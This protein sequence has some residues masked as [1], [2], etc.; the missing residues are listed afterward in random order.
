M[1]RAA[2]HRSSGRKALW[3][4]VVAA[5]IA[6]AFVVIPFAS[7]AN[8]D[9][10][11]FELDG[12][13][14][15]DGAAPSQDWNTLFGATG[16]D[17]GGTALSKV[18]INDGTSSSDTG[19]GSGQTKDTADVSQWT[20]VT[21]T[22]T[23][24]KDNIGYAY[25]ANYV[26]QG[27][28]VLYFGQERAF[29]TKG[30]DANVGFWF[31]QDPQVGLNANGTFNGHHVDG[32]LLV[33]SEFT[34]G[35]SIAG[36]RVY[37]W[38][39]G[40]AV[41]VGSLN[42]SVCAAGVLGTKDACAITNSTTITTPWSN[43]ASPYF[44]EGG[45]NLSSLYKGGSLPCF[46]QFLT[47][48]RTSQAPNADL[49][50]FAFGGLNT[51]GRITIVKDAQPNDAQSF[52]FTAGNGLSPASFS[53]TDNGDAAAATQTFDKLQPGTYTITETNIP[54]AW[55]L[56]GVNCTTS[57][58]GTSVSGPTNGA[59][60]VTVGLA[61]NV[62]CTYVNKRDQGYLK[63]SK[64]FDA[65]T[66]GF[67]G[68]F[69]IKYNCGAGDVTVN[70][71]GGASTTVGP[72]NTGTS[73][74]VSEPVLPTAPT[75]WTFGTPVVAGSPAVITKGDQAA[76]VGVTVTNS[77]TR[78]QGYLKISKVFDAKT[79]G[80]AGTFAIKYNCGAGDVTVNV[81]GG[82]ST[83]VGPFNTGTSCSVSEP[84]LPTAPTGWTFGTPVVAG[85]PAVITKGDQAA[86]VGVTVTNSITR[87]Q[88]YLK[89][90]K[91]FDAKTSGFAGTFAIKYNCG[92]GDVT[93]NVAGGASTTVGPFNTGTS[94]SVS[95]PVL[96]TAPTGWTFGTPV[97]A[98]SPAVITKGDQ[99]A[100]VG[101]TVTNSIT[102]DTGSLTL[103]K[104]LVG[105]PDGYKG[106]F[107]ISYDCND[108]DTHDGSV[109][110]DAGET[111]SPISGI[112][113]GTQ[114]TISET[115]PAAPD[116]Y[117]FVDPSFSPAATVTIDANNQTVSVVTTNTLTRDTGKITVVKE[118]VGAPEGAKVTLQIKSGDTVVQSG[119]VADGGS[120]SK[121]VAT[122]EYG[123]DETSA[124]GDV[125][126]DLYDSSVVC[127]NGE[128]TV[129]ENA[130]GA[131]TSVTVAKGDDITC[132][133]TNTRKA[134]SITVEKTVSATADGTYVKAPDVATKPENGGTFF[135]K[136]KVTNTSAAD[137]ITVTDLAD[138][139]SD[140]EIDV[141]SLVC[142]TPET[143]NGLPFTLAPG[144]SI[145]CTFTHDLIGN[146]GA[147]ETDHVDVSWKDQEGTTQG[148]TS[149]NDAIIALTDVKPAISVTKTANPTV[150]QDSGLVTFTAVVTNTSSVD[151]LTIDTLTD[152]IY[153]NLLT[154][155]TKAT[156]KFGGNVVSLPFTLPVHES[157]VCTFQ[158]TVTQTE[159]DVVT[160]SGTDEEQNRVT[161]H[162]DAT[163][164]VNHT[165][166][167]PP[168][169]PKT[170][171][172]IQKDATAQVT[173]G[174]NG[175]ATIVYDVAVK[176]NGPDPAAN[177]AVSDPAPSGVT[178]TSV[179]Q[180]PSQGSCSIQSGGALLTCSIGTLAVG[181]SVAIK[182]NATV[183]QTG[184]ITNTGTTTTTTPD[185]NP[186]NNTDSAQTIVVAP[187]K[188]PVKPVVAPEICNTV[189]VTPK[190][191][192]GNGKSQKITVKVT[193]GKK[194]VAGAKVK[195]TGPGI[196]KT[197]T[198][199]K[200]GKVTVTVKP[201]KPGI[202]RVEIQNKKACNTQRIG[203]VGVFEPPV[204]G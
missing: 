176:N 55:S 126:L 64:V 92:A 61:G 7:S 60:T 133:I 190:M 118:F 2:S 38:A 78:D 178:F 99:A 84:V 147:T 63:I 145:T 109:E 173:L 124:A 27:N 179:A 58:P 174:S 199:G 121:V 20:W 46:S 14:V 135:F 73:C 110:L 15:Q 83:T 185:T 137:T 144:A 151:P 56:N 76:A 85:S 70:V 196:S 31:L 104:V 47:D 25:A 153:G 6:T 21:G 49:K 189:T 4:C 91:V 82:A 158:A 202:I 114:C 41:E 182:V 66:S 112:P 98:G 24:A 159:T 43:P 40:S 45:L 148:P 106:P 42:E 143:G 129:S 48:T 94:C 59:I 54:S 8:P 171:V 23:P 192:K 81:A 79:S 101:V 184:T 187:L 116:G 167:P 57:G 74:S 162:D 139:I 197:V 127:K 152:S 169:A 163:V 3:L 156:C 168:P 77:I 183:T 75:G 51:C 18:W 138:L 17:V 117:T 201:S 28:Q 130:D 108:G 72:F 69:A 11:G 105:G 132:T 141:G 181:Q 97:V 50:D 115:P 154:G 107:T 200:N 150:V 87:D 96:P 164:T 172:A 155:S 32:D 194:G 149:S 195:I 131:D 34:T 142:G 103:K 86:A 89:I 35:G 165:P 88:G 65:K 37:K 93:V 119:S 12:N 203:V 100:A 166:P 1:R 26:D 90:S 44:F 128:T 188:P 10:S 36:I 30:G 62:T 5:V 95:E 39:S 67:A 180:Q 136:V 157:L 102:R 191:L 170:D 71:A 9:I 122:G 123:V 186:A 19:F 33:Q 52:S 177:V 160:S 161:A 80:F 13:T 29:D 175:Q 198:S 134:R 146:A 68:T 204:T 16:N 53:L 22:V 113:T 111:S 193:Q 140:E 125:D 120:I